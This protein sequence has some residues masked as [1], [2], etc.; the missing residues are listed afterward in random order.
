[1]LNYDSDSTGYGS[2]S[3]T[4]SPLTASQFILR[5]VTVLSSYSHHSPYEKFNLDD[6]ATSSS[7]SSSWSSR[8]TSETVSHTISIVNTSFSA[9]LDR[10]LA[11]NS[12]NVG[13]RA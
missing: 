7:D 8:T 12:G 6:Y 2:S 13:S 9:R 1:M 4:S 10:I 5:P 11:L 3:D